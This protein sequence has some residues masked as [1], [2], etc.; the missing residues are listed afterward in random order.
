VSVAENEAFDMDDTGASET[1]TGSRPLTRGGAE[2]PSRAPVT[3][4]R[5]PNASV[6]CASAQ[7]LAARRRQQCAR[8]LV[9]AKPRRP[10]RLRPIGAMRLLGEQLAELGGQLLD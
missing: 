6:S 5:R 9:D 4:V 1:R 3:L 10:L 8:P 2:V 7:T